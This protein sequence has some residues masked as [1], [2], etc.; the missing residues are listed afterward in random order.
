MSEVANAD[1]LEEIKEELEKD[2]PLIACNVWV[3]IKDLEAR[4]KILEG[5]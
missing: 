4:I 3:Y 2:K 5:K 1:N